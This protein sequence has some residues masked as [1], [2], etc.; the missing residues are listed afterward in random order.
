MNLRYI[1]FLFLLGF[2][3]SISAQVTDKDKRKFS[4]PAVESEKEKD[5]TP[6]KVKVAPKKNPEKEKSNN[7]SASID[8]INKK[9]IE[10]PFSMVG[11]DGLRNPG[12][13][14][15][16]RWK[17]EVLAT[18]IRRYMSDQFLGEYK[19]DSK[20]VNIICRDHEYPDGDR[21]SVS[22]NDN[23]AHRNVLLTSQYRRLQINLQEG[24]NKI[25][26]KALNQG[27][28][29]PNTAEFKVYDDKGNLV[30][31]KEWNLLTGVKASITFINEK[32][33]IVRA[34]KEEN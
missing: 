12:E 3:L 2:G 6:I 23:I 32:P 27:D 10:K 31:S 26:I 30:S 1:I 14:F 34:E 22:V 7:K 17:K 4:I 9:E 19:I 8:R 13:I 5:S 21:V 29:G 18:G 15:A 16:K 20:F 28:S 11:G 25:D 33:K 24:I